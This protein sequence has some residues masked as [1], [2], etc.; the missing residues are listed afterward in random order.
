LELSVDVHAAAAGTVVCVS[1]RTEDG[2][3]M[4]REENEKACTEGA[5]SG[6][7]KIDHGN[8][9][10]SIYLHLSSANVHANDPVLVGDIIGVSGGTGVSSAPHLHFE[11]RKK[12]GNNLIPVDPYGWRGSE[13]D[14]Y[15]KATNVNLWLPLKK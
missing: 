4:H 10:F 15:T 5:H 1:L 9:Y 13:H 7:I 12:I 11:V 6:E 8:G 3:A 2:A 14:P